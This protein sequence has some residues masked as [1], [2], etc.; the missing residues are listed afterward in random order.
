MKILFCTDGSKISYNAIKNIS[1]WV[2]E[3]VIDIICVIDWSFLPDDITLESSGFTI[4]CANVAD[5]ILDYAEKL[6]DEAGFTKGK[7]IKNC[8]AAIE[9]ILEQ[10][11]NE[12]YDLILMGS[13]GKKVFKNGSGLFHRRL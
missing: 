5:S 8:G 6:V 13:H 1:G 12:Y 7:R 3:A 2:K 10:A 9:S 11:E 4:S